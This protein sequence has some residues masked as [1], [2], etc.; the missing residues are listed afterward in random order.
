MRTRQELAHWL[1]DVLPAERARALDAG[2]GSHSLLASFG[3]RI[4]YLA[5]VDVRPPPD[6]HAWLDEFRLADL[7]R[8]VEAFSAGEF[9][10]VLCAFA[11]EH[12]PDPHSALLTMHDWLRPGGWLILSTVNRRHPFVSAYMSLPNPLG[13]PLQRLLKRNPA[14]AHPLVGACN[15]PADLRAALVSAGFEQITMRTTDHL[16]RAWRRFP[17]ARLLGALGDRATRALSGRRSTI[18]VRAQHPSPPH[19]SG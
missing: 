12:L 10:V 17:P 4:A 3:P 1:D 11:L 9:D 15:T 13:R 6:G 5:G 14:D 2:C 7:C 8:D 16:A 19:P 18:I